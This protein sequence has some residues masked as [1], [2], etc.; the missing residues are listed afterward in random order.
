V[1][2][3][4]PADFAGGFPAIRVHGDLL[5]RP[6]T[7]RYGALSSLARWAGLVIDCPSYLP[8]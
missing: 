1:N 3:I 5:D 2:F 6:A 4:T 8:T 7:G